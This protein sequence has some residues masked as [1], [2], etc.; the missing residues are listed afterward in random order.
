MMA[1]ESSSTWNVDMHGRRVV[2]PSKSVDDW[3]SE[4]LGHNDLF[5]KRKVRYSKQMPKKY[6]NILL[7][8]LQLSASIIHQ[9]NFY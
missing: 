2:T 6:Q 3:S 5:K 7:K 8:R 9:N 4:H 1:R